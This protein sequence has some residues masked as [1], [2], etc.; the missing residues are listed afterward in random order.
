MDRSVFP[1]VQGGPH[2]HT[3]AAIAVALHEASQPSYQSYAQQ[4]L[5][6]A[7]IMA[8]RFLYHGY[9][10]VTGGTDNHMVV[11]DFSQSDMPDGKKAESVLDKI[12]ISTSKSSV[13]DDS[14]PP[15]RPSGLRVGIQAMTTRGVE[16]EDTKQIVDFIHDAFVH[17]DDAAYLE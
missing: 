5:A 17:R 3:V 4:I 14:N 15:F 2:M 7:Q 11:V 6:N 16:E 10:L 9:D 13:P 12:G 8:E 1:G